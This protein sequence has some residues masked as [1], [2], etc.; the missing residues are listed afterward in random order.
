MLGKRRNPVAAWLGLPLITLGVYSLV[1]FYK[2]T[3]EVAEYARIRVRPGVSVLAVSLGVLLIV[4]PF[5]AVWRLCERAS[6]ARRAAGLPP[7][8]VPLAFLLF[9]IGFGPLYLQIQIN[10]IWDR[11]PMA[12][13]GQQV[14]LVR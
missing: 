7:L 9:L 14:P 12:V 2:T 11:Y 1:W 6:A 8:P 10:Q 3:R 4:P 13:E 5:V